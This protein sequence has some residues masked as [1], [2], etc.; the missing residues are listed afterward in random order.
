MWF[1]YILFNFICS[2]FNQ[3]QSQYVNNNLTDNTYIENLIPNMY[4]IP[5]NGYIKYLL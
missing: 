1:I 4:N 5:N 2:L 3:S